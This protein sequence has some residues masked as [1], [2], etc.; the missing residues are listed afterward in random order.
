MLEDGEL[1]WV[2]HRLPAAIVADRPIGC[3]PEQ[4][5]TAIALS[6]G[7]PAMTAPGRVVTDDGE[8]SRAEVLSATGG[9]IRYVLDEAGSGWLV[10]RMLRS[11]V[12]AVPP[13]PFSFAFE[14]DEPEGSEVLTV[15]G[16]I[17]L[18]GE[19]P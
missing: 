6:R 18:A 3:D 17:R 2:V 5:Y 9:E 19:V 16:A 1:L 15:R 11:D 8:F 13:T 12:T 10:H 7:D 14:T 4:P